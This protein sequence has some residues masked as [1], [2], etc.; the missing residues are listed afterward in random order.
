MSPRPRPGMR[1]DRHE[2]RSQDPGRLHIR[3]L[4]SGRRHRCR[5]GS[6]PH[7]LFYR[8]TR[9]IS[10]WI[11][12]SNGE[13]PNVLSTDDLRVLRRAVLPRP[14]DGH[15]LHGTRTSP[16]SASGSSGRATTRTSACS[17]TAPSRPRSSFGSTAGRTSP[18]CSRSRTRSRRKAS[19]YREERG[20]RARA[21]L[22]SRA[23]RAGGAHRLLRRHR[24]D[25]RHDARL[26][27]HAP[28]AR[29]SGAR[30]LRRV[31]RSPSRPASS[32]TWHAEETARPNIGASLAEWLE[33]APRLETD[34]DELAHVY[35]QSLVDLA[36]LRFYP[37]IIPG[38]S[39]PAAGLPWFMA[40]SGGTA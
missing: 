15:D 29:E 5:P 9:F 32:S 35:R 14:R 30:G 24:L 31:R 36:A 13:R 17:T 2:R 38:A 21:R 34:W 11:L 6:A 28:A 3:R 18:T 19:C 23:V 12:T 20:G 4:R 39:M 33:E 8:D 22:P 25:R 16:C 7:G 1:G 27:A 26:P 10:R 40:C 37:D